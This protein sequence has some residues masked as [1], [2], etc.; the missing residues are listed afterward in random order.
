MGILGA[1]PPK[2]WPMFKEAPCLAM[3]CSLLLTCCSRRKRAEF[4]SNTT[5]KQRFTLLVRRCLEENGI[6][7][8][9]A[10]GDAD[11]V[12]VQVAVRSAMEYAT[13]LEELLNIIRCGCTTDCSSHRCNRR[14][15]G[16]SCTTAC[17][18]CRGTSCLN[19]MLPMDEEQEEPQCL[20]KDCI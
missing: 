20:R 7:V 5:N 12:I 15:V 2:T 19:S 16:L 18:Q 11:C 8:Q 13:V 10:Q 17:E 3:M 9:H 14:K 1:L 6:L 4:L